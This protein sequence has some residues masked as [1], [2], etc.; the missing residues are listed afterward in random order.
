MIFD[1]LE[2]RGS[3]LSN[4][5]KTKFKLE[6]LDFLEQKQW[7]VCIKLLNTLYHMYTLYTGVYIDPR[8]R[9]GVYIGVYILLEEKLCYGRCSQ[10]QI[11][12]N[13]ILEKS[14]SGINN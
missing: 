14:R 2:R 9:A 6:D 11:I 1:S 4:A 12:T 8:Y 5:S 13:F 7:G 3:P 10:R